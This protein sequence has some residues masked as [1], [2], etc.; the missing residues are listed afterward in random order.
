LSFRIEGYGEGLVTPLA[1][2]PTIGS[3]PMSLSSLINSGE[4]SG[5]NAHLPN[6]IG[7]ELERQ[8]AGRSHWT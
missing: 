3:Q 6:M 2:S 1:V 7:D 8:Q 5:R 4:A